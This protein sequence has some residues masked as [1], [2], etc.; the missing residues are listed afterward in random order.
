MALASRW[1]TFTVTTTQNSGVGFMG[2]GSLPPP[3]PPPV[4]KEKSI[5]IEKDK[6]THARREDRKDPT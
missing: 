3:I 2:Y 5:S 1:L 4:K 6:Y